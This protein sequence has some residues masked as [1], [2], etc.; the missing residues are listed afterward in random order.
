MT[1]FVTI[2][3]TVAKYSNKLSVSY[4]SRIAYLSYVH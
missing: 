2:P 3:G 4:V 1:Y